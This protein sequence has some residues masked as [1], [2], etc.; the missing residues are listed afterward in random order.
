VLKMRDHLSG[1]RKMI[2]P[3]FGLAW[4]ALVWGW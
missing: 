4:A 1:I 3:L 2:L